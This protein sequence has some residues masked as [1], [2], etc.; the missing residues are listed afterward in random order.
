MAEEMNSGEQADNSKTEEYRYENYKLIEEKFLKDLNENP[1]YDEFFS[2]FNPIAV[3]IFKENYAWKKTSAAIWGP[4]S[5]DR[6]E[7]Y[8]QR[9]TELAWEK[10]WEIQQRKLFDLQCR[11][12]AEQ[13]KIPE[14]VISF[15]FHYWSERIEKCPFLTPISEIE[16]ERYIQYLER[17]SYDNIFVFDDD[18]QDYNDFKARHLNIDDDI[19]SDPPPW[20]DYYEAVTGLS[21]LYLLYDYRGKKKKNI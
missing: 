9:Y 17:N 3:K 21:S 11:W 18:W 14:I 20:Y 16:L 15:D 12:R 2:Q 8:L 13:L 4:Q 1:R 5:I 10:L 6:Y 19:A 7:G